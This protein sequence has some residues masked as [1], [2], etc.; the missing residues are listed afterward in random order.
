MTTDTP[1]KSESPD[2]YLKKEGIT[3][4]DKEVIRTAPK[5]TISKE[6]IPALNQPNETKPNIND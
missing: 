6:A 3:G 5:S 1:I 2:E 4:L